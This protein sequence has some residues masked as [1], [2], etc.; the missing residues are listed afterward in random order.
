MEFRQCDLTSLEVALKTVADCEQ[1]MHL[2]AIPDPFGDLPL[3]AVLGRNTVLAY[4]VFEAARRSGIRRV[5]YAGSESGSGF[6]IH[7][8]ELSPL[9]LPIDEAHPL[10]CHEA[11]S[12]SKYFGERIGGN[13]AKAF[14]LEV[15]SLRY[16]HV[17]LRRNVEAVKHTVTQ[18]RRGNGLAALEPKDRLGAYIAVRDVARAFAAATSFQ[19]GF[20]DTPFEAFY[21]SARNTCIE[22]P[23]LELA[24]SQIRLGA[25][26]L[27][28]ARLFEDNPHASMYDIRKGRTTSGLATSLD[29]AELRAMG[30]VTGC[31]VCDSRCKAGA[32]PDSCGAPPA[33][34]CQATT[35]SRAD[36]VHETRPV[37][38]SRQSAPLPH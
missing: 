18:A 20:A 29:L 4:N 15:V 13:Y 2:A 38:G 3:E 5:V 37:T 28:D 24:T 9:Y 7:E 17:W 22:V 6:G 35:G 30:I 21:L 33:A 36:G 12:L 32:E 10:W 31:P 34:L 11:Y 23:T 27:N 14:G 26:H 1:I 25:C 16:P 19:F 8:A